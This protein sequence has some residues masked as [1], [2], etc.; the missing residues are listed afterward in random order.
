M[1]DDMFLFRAAI[2]ILTFAVPLATLL[3]PEFKYSSASYNLANLMGNVLGVVVLFNI[4]MFWIRRKI[5][6]VP[7]GWPWWRHVWDVLET[8]LIVVALLTFGFLP[9]TQAITEMVFRKGPKKQH[10]ATEKVKI[11]G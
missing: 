10:Y 4:P 1:F 8:F 5:S 3:S 11:G 2:Y 6:P 7:R 9:Y